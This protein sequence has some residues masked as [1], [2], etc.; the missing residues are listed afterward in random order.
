MGL[1]D[2]ACPDAGGEAV[3]GIVGT[4]RELLGVIERDRR[5]HGPEDFFLYDIHVFFGVDQNSGLYE[6]AFAIDLASPCR[7]AGAP[8][9]SDLYLVANPLAL[10][11]RNHRAYSG[12]G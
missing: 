5:Y 12:L 8:P 10:L 11:F 9:H 7:G 2:V 4:R 3:D 1:A 6:V